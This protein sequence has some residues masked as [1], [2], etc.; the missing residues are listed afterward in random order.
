VIYPDYVKPG[1]LDEIRGLP[2]D[3][4]K[5]YF[6]AGGT[7]L[8]CYLRDGM[9]PRD[10]SIV[11]DVSALK[12]LKGITDQGD[13]IRIGA[14]VT[15]AEISESELLKKWS[16]G[17]VVASRLIGTPQIAN[18]A[19]LGGNVGNASPAGDSLPVLTAHSAK[20]ETFSSQ[21]GRMLD[22][23]EVFIGPKKTTLYN[24]EL[25][26]AIYVPKLKP[27]PGF[28]VRGAFRKIGGRK[29][30]IISKASVSVCA[31][32]DS[33]GNID[34]ANVAFG[35]VGPRVIQGGAVSD[36]LKCKCVNGDLLERCCSEIKT[37]ITPI[38]DFRSTAEYRIEVMRP[39]FL[40]AMA[41]ITSKKAV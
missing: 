27:K 41:D 34:Y 12:E 11:V 10:K 6:L 38:D 1:S 30:H 22:V 23:S 40:Q 26:A 18:R 5:I 28:S 16:P 33:A 29:S 13:T 31:T 35:A 2:Q 19:T 20:I 39:L 37:I 9:L 24:G 36:L 17:L 25:I 15:F 32:I 14:V 21:P 3:G 7:D 8:M 4:R